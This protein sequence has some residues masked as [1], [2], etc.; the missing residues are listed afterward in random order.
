MSDKFDCAFLFYGTPNLEKWNP[1]GIRTKV[2]SFYGSDDKI[3]YLSDY[4]T[5]KSFMERCKPN[6]SLKF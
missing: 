1:I 2:V 4:N 3:K 5:Y 6:S